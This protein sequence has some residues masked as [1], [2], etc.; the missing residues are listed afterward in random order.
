MHGGVKEKQGVRTM[1]E[2]KQELCQ[3]QVC[4]RRYNRA[5]GTCI[6]G[7]DL[8]IFGKWISE[9]EKPVPD[10]PTPDKP[11]PDNPTPD[12]PGPGKPE[13]D[14]PKP[15]KPEPN[16]QKPKKPVPD[17]PTPDNPTPDKP[18]PYKPKW[19]EPEP[20]DPKPKKKRGGLLKRIL[21]ALV[22]IIVCIV[23]I[24][25]INMI[26]FSGN[27]YD[28]G[29]TPSYG[30]ETEDIAQ[31]DQQEDEPDGEDDGEPE[32]IL[33]DPAEEMLP[34]DQTGSAASYTVI[35]D[36][37]DIFLNIFLYPEDAD[38][39][40]DLLGWEYILENGMNESFEV[41]FDEAESYDM[42]VVADTGEVFVYP[43]LSFKKNATFLF[44]EDSETP[45][46][47]IIERDGQTTP[48]GATSTYGEIYAQAA[49][50]SIPLL[51]VTKYDFEGVYVYL[52]GSFDRGE[53]LTERYLS[54][55]MMNSGDTL[56]FIM[57]SSL[58]H[59]LYLV[60]TEGDGWMYENV[61]L[62]E[63][64]CAINSLD[65]DGEPEL[66][67]FRSDGEVEVVYGSLWDETDDSSG[68][69]DFRSPEYS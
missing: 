16:K 67:L 64:Y 23:L 14:K 8:S 54:D 7:A 69:N 34:E 19:D 9:S 58:P 3:C 68:E 10:N 17:N 57:E 21:I 61:D 31:E 1:S 25:V 4:G 22:A 45:R 46:L 48:R 33:E 20:D 6:C 30:D 37:E 27:D 41:S 65:D 53:N 44:A 40:V 2:E 42:A 5:E 35:N 36:T 51:N 49:T 12:K 47:T 29:S 62:S 52:R 43:A 18:K 60:D 28:Y 15:D 59:Y 26:F 39:G 11:V 56:K 63:V 38:Y 24:I 32:E 50:R 13:P 55:E 66:S